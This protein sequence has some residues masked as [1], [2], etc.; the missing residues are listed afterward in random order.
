MSIAFL[1]G[2]ELIIALSMN[3]KANIRRA[4]ADQELKLIEQ[5]S[6][7]CANLHKEFE[8]GL[9]LKERWEEEVEQ[10]EKNFKMQKALIRGSLDSSDTEM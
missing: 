3:M 5:K 8:S 1:C 2:T 4:Q 6:Q 10:M 9:I 7:M